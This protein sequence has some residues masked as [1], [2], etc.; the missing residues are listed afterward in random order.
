MSRTVLSVGRSNQML[1]HVLWAALITGS[2]VSSGLSLS[3]CSEVESCKPGTAGCVEAGPKDGECQFD[4]VLRNGKC[5]NPADLDKDEDSGTDEADS[6]QV[7]ACAP[8]ESPALCVPER[9]ECVDFCETPE[10]IPGSGREVEQITCGGERDAMDKPLVLTF[11]E[12]CTNTCLL[13]CRWQN[14]FCPGAKTD[15]SAE[16]AKPYVQT[17][18]SLPPGPSGGCLNDLA[19]Q[20]NKCTEVRALGCVADATLCPNT[21][22][23]APVCEGITCN[24][25]CKN[26]M[27]AQ[28]NAFDGYCDDGAYT[29]SDTDLCTFGADCADCG[30]RNMPERAVDKGK[31]ELGEPC[32]NSARCAGR[33]SDFDINKSWCLDVA[34]DVGRCLADCSG[35]DETC[36]QGFKC[37]ALSNS[38]GA[39]LID[40][41]GRRG[42]VCYP[43]NQNQCN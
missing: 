12:T 24:N 34:A 23:M 18:C 22:G 31:I 14:W 40:G 4:L 43:D 6:G 25:Q 17:D 20:R 30:P 41:R 7:S 1:K 35:D 29:F 10:E 37:T 26:S 38:S 36:P 42:K 33:S 39:D 3:A 9:E 15:C 21:M 11:A 8:C 16:C 28:A 13:T 5:M 32:P 2:V 27:S 19:C